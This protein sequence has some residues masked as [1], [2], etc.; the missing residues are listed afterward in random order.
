MGKWDLLKRQVYFES[1]LCW[2]VMI[3]KIR[4]NR[5]RRPFHL[6]WGGRSPDSD[7]LYHNDLDESLGAQHLASLTTAFS[8]VQDSA[9]VQHRVASEAARLADLLRQ[10]ASIMVCG[11][12]A[13][14]RAVRDEFEAI[15][16]PLGQSVP[17]LKQRGRYLEDIF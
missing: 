15:L 9:Y 3:V 1:L 5:A 7:F 8:R 14:A 10:G 4:A 6:F 16:A 11:G 12:D 2:Q 17:A 13:M